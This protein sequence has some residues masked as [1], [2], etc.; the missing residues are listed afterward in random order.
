MDLTN[1]I[2][3]LDDEEEE[4]KPLIDAQP[5][6]PAV[7]PSLS[8]VFSN[9]DELD[10]AVDNFVPKSL[11][12]DARDRANK[13][14]ELLSSN[15]KQMSP[16]F[17][18]MSK[19][20]DELDNVSNDVPAEGRMPFWEGQ[21]I[22]DPDMFIDEIN[23]QFNSYNEN[24]DESAFLGFGES[25]DA[26][27]AKR[28]LPLKGKWDGIVAKYRSAATD[29]DEL[30]KYANEAYSVRD[31][32]TKRY[33]SM[34][35]PQRRALQDIWEA[36]NGDADETTRGK[37]RSRMTAE[38]GY[39]PYLIGGATDMM[40]HAARTARARKAIHQESNYQAELKREYDEQRQLEK[41]GIR[42]TKNGYFAGFPLNVS[43]KEAEILEN[44][45]A[46]PEGA[47]AKFGEGEVDKARFSEVFNASMLDFRAARHQLM[48][49]NASKDPKKIEEA[50][51]G[52]ALYK[53][54]MR[55]AL[56]KGNDMEMLGDLVGRMQSREEMGLAMGLMKEIA[57]EKR[58]AGED[59]WSNSIKSGLA[60]TWQS[61]DVIQ[62]AVGLQSDEEHIKK[63]AEYAAQ[64][65]MRA[66]PLSFDD[67]DG[68]GS[69]FDLASEFIGTM[70]AQY[71]SASPIG[72]AAGATAQVAGTFAENALE[73][74]KKSKGLNRFKYLRG[75]LHLTD[76]VASTKWG[77]K[78]LGGA[79]KNRAAIVGGGATAATVEYGGSYLEAIQ[80][81]KTDADPE[82]IDA[83][84]QEA[85]MRLLNDPKALAQVRRA[86]LKR[87][88][89]IAAVEA[90]TMF[91]GGLTTKTLRRMGATGA[92]VPALSRGVVDFGTGA[93]GEIAGM[94]MMHSE[95][96]MSTPFVT[97]GKNKEGKYEIGGYIG[98]N[99]EDIIMEGIAGPMMD[100]GQSA[101]QKTV[102]T[103][104]EFTQQK[105]YEWREA[106]KK[107]LADKN[108]HA[109]VEAITDEAI[110]AE[111]GTASSY[112]GAARVIGEVT[113][114]EHGTSGIVDL[115]NGKQ[116]EFHTA[117]DNESLQQLF[118]DRFGEGAM[119]KEQA[120]F[121]EK[122]F[123]AMEQ[124]G[125]SDWRD[126]KIVFA[127]EMAAGV[128]GSPMSFNQTNNV[129]TVNTSGDAGLSNYG[130]IKHEKTSNTSVTT[131]KRLNETRSLVA[132]LVHEV[133]HFSERYMVGDSK[134]RK[135]FEAIDGNVK[136]KEGKKQG[137]FLAHL[138]YNLDARREAE[139]ST[140][141]WKKARDEFY[142]RYGADDK[143]AN[144]TKSEW[145][146]FQFSRVAR[147]QIQGMDKSV[148]G[149][150]K[151]FYQKLR[152]AFK[153]MIGDKNLSNAEA[154]KEIASMFGFEGKTDGATINNSPTSEVADEEQLARD[155]ADIARPVV[156]PVE[157]TAD[158]TSS[159]E[160]DAFEKDQDLPLPE[161]KPAKPKAPKKGKK[162]KKTQQTDT[163]ESQTTDVSSAQTPTAG[164]K[165]SRGDSDVLAVRAKKKSA[166]SLK[167]VIS[168]KNS[169]Q[170]EKDAALNEVKDR[171][172]KNPKSS[173][174]LIL[175]SLEKQKVR[176]EVAESKKA[177]TAAQKNY[178]T[179][180]S[181]N[182]EKVLGKNIKG[183]SLDK[184]PYFNVN[185][186][187][188]IIGI[189]NPETSEWSGIKP[190]SRRGRKKKVEKKTD[191]PKPAKI[192]PAKLKMQNEFASKAFKDPEKYL[193][194]PAVSWLKNNDN[195]NVKADG[196][197]TGIRD[198]ATG[199]W[200]G[201]RNNFVDESFNLDGLQT[202]LDLGARKNTTRVKT[203][204]AIDEY[205]DAD[206]EAD[207]ALRNIAKARNMGVTRD[208]EVE[209]VAR[210]EKGDIIGGTFTSTD[211][212]NVSF[213]VVVSADAEGAGVGSTLVDGAIENARARFDEL[214]EGSDRVTMQIDVT[215]PQMKEMLERR[216]F[217]VTQ[218]TGKNR[219]SMEPSDYNNIGNRSGD[220][221]ARGNRKEEILKEGR[222]AKL[223][224]AAKEGLPQKD[225]KAWNALID[226]EKP[227]KRVTPP[228]VKELP[229]PQE[230]LVT[231]EDEAS[232]KGLR[233]L[234]KNLHEFV[235]KNRKTANRGG[236]PQGQVV[237]VRID[238]PAFK[239][240]KE[241]MEK[242]LRDAPVYASVIHQ[243]AGGKV[244]SKL[245]IDSIVHLKNGGVHVRSPETTSKIAKGEKDK[246]PMATLKG[247]YQ[248]R[249]D[250]PKDIDSYEQVGF[251]PERHSHFYKRG[252]ST[253]GGHSP[254]TSFKE[255]VLIGNTAYVK[256]A[257]F[258]DAVNNTELYAR[259]SLANPNTLG[260]RGGSNKQLN[261]TSN[262]TIQR[263]IASGRVYAQKV[264]GNAFRADS[265]TQGEAF[266]AGIS[267]TYKDHPVG[268]AV[269]V[270]DLDFY[271]DPKNGIFMSGDGLAGVAITDYADLVS[272]F[273]HPTSTAKP[274]EI[275]AEASQYAKTLDAYDVGGFLPNLYSEFGFK[276]VARVKFN[277]E[278]APDGWPYEL[279]GEPDI[280]LMVKDPETSFAPIAMETKGFDK[281][282]E[283]VPYMEAD[284]AWD[285]A[286]EIGQQAQSLELGARKGEPDHGLLGN[287][288]NGEILYNKSGDLGM[289]NHTERIGAPSRGNPWRYRESSGAVY[290]WEGKPTEMDKDAV[291]ILLE[292]KGYDTKN[293]KF[294]Q[295]NA[296][297]PNFAKDYE[298]AHAFPLKV[299]SKKKFSDEFGA[300]KGAKLKLTG[301]IK[302]P[303]GKVLGSYK[304]A[305]FTGK[306][307]THGWFF[308]DGSFVNVFDT[309]HIHALNDIVKKN[310][311][312]EVS[313]KVIEGKLQSSMAMDYGM[314]PMK[315]LVRQ[316]TGNLSMED[317]F[318]AGLVRVRVEKDSFGRNIY[319]EGNGKNPPIDSATLAAELAAING[320]FN[321]WWENAANETYGPTL[322]Y[323]KYEGQFGME[324][325][326]RSKNWLSKVSNSQD[327]LRVGTA[328]TGKKTQNS[329]NINKNMVP[330]NVFEKHMEQMDSEHLPADIRNEKNPDAK[331][332]KLVTFF[333]KNLIALHDKFPAKLRNRA[334]HWYDGALD[335]AKAAGKA[336]GKTAEQAAGVIAVMSP[337]K[338][339][340]KNVAQGQQFM[341]MWRTEQKTVITE[342]YARDVIEHIV[343]NTQ[344]S[345]SRKKKAPKDKEETERQKTI[346]LNYNK[347]ITKEV[348]AERRILLEAAIGSSIDQLSAKKDSTKRYWTMRIILQAKFGSD[349][350]TLAPEGQ[351][352]G[353]QLTDKGVPAMNGWG[354]NSEMKKAIS[355]LENGSIENISNNVGN[356]HKVRNFYNNIIA[357]NTPM[358]DATIDTHAVAA[359]HLLPFSGKSLEVKQNFG[360][361]A[362]TGKGVKGMYYMYLDAYKQAAQAK[363]LM[364][365][366]MQSI[367]WE[368]VRLLY[369]KE[370]KSPKFLGQMQKVWQ[371][372]SN[373]GAARKQLTS[374]KI[375][376]PIWAGGNNSGELAARQT[377]LR[378][379]GGSQAN[380]RGSLRFGDRRS[381]T[382]SINGVELDP[383]ED[384]TGFN[385]RIFGGDLG[386]RQGQ[387]P[388]IANAKANAKQVASASQQAFL[389]QSLSFVER[390]KQV[391]EI[392][393]DPIRLKLQDKMLPVRRLIEVLEE[394]KGG[395]FDDKLQT[396]VQH[397]NYHGKTGAELTNQSEDHER[398]IAQSI[399]ENKVDVEVLDD[400]LHLRH[401]QERNA[402]N[403]EQSKVV[404]VSYRKNGRLVQKQFRSYGAE[405][406]A[407]DFS[408]G[409]KVSWENTFADGTVE[410]KTKEFKEQSKAEAFA[411]KKIKRTQKP[412]WP[413]QGNIKL[414][415]GRLQGR[416]IS[417][418][419]DVE[420]G[421][422]YSDDAARHALALNERAIY[423]MHVA[424]KLTEPQRDRIVR[425]IK[426]IKQNPAGVAAYEHT[427]R[428]VDKM[429]RLSLE[430]QYKSGLI[431]KK[432]FDR[433][434]K[435]YKHFIPLR[436]WE[437][438]SSYYD[439]SNVDVKTQLNQTVLPISRGMNTMKHKFR[440]SGGLVKDSMVSNHLA[441][442]FA[443]ARQGIVESQKNEVMRSFFDLVASA[444]KD[445]ALKGMS[446]NLF[447]YTKGVMITTIDKYGKPRKQL[448]PRWKDDPNIVGMKINGVTVALRL[449]GDRLDGTS[450]VARALKNLGAEKSGV[451][452]NTVKVVTR[453]MAALRTTL[454][455]AFTPV[456]FV[457]D[458][459][460]GLYSIKG[461]DSDFKDQV[462]RGE[463]T[464]QKVEQI[465]TRAL[466][467]MYN[468][469][470][471][472]KAFQGALLQT[473]GGRGM[474]VSQGVEKLKGSKFQHSAEVQ[475]WADI[476]QDFS[477]NGGRINF[478][479]FDSVQQ[480]AK[481]FGSSVREFD[482]NDPQRMKTFLTGAYEFMDKTSGAVENLV[483]VTAYDAFV[484]EGISKQKAA[485]L[486]LNLTTNFTRKGEWTTALNGMYL[487]FNAG[488]QGSAKVLSTAYKSPKAR[489]FLGGAVLLG[490]MNSFINRLMSDE[491]DELEMSSWDR[492][493]PYSKTHNLHFFLPSFGEKHAKIPTPYGI[494]VFT[495]AGT[496]LESTI[497][498][499]MKLGDAASTW[500]ATALESFS[501][502][503]GS[504][505]ASALTPTALQPIMDLSLNQDFKGAPIY[506]EDKFNEGTP[507]SALHWSNT[508]EMSKSIAQGLNR[509]TGGDLQRSGAIDVSPDT[510]DYMANYI[511]GGLGSFIGRSGD[512]ASK[513]TQSDEASPTLNDIPIL[514]R[515]VGDKTVYYDTERFYNLVNHTGVSKERIEHY[516]KNG[517][518]EEAQ[519]VIQYEAPRMKLNSI[520]K[521]TVQK[522]LATLRR[523]IESVENHK[524]LSGQQKV[525]QIEILKRKRTRLMN[526]F[527]KTAE[528]MGIDDY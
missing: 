16:L 474:L 505:M 327:S 131:G 223:V 110:E 337:Q 330:R 430:R 258:G 148:L 13:A 54:V 155:S 284:S 141:A 151:K 167:R 351:T 173:A 353:L 426:T 145:W 188:T 440:A 21:K 116:H 378:E 253:D 25:D 392:A 198:P 196:T 62:H 96:G 239:K 375:S 525:D 208:R 511:F 267:R 187:G 39:D 274:K 460:M 305:K 493:S 44:H 12:N 436:G 382:D 53:R 435:A 215:N 73:K 199:E 365:R 349:Y 129:L 454:S 356:A 65:K 298:D 157:E 292:S 463:I 87:T 125:G 251:D 181:K 489:K 333:R 22:E 268:K 48:I 350:N 527:I 420:A 366:Q 297:S 80:H 195:F 490:F 202:E 269:E 402:V 101:L 497:F 423:A 88:G 49:A 479:G 76:A 482:P 466:R 270:K 64:S 55:E 357:P 324:L 192:A 528:R 398:P 513:V 396:Y 410:T 47:L 510:I 526:K 345:D 293:L 381:S 24:K 504:S 290:F 522:Q 34:G 114:T 464:E 415:K 201:E 35:D 329:V 246:F 516:R 113:Q 495:S 153:D 191:A 3:L 186:E 82:G 185:K 23:N 67:V 407:K 135:L 227:I 354:S 256:G 237:D 472:R 79:W 243:E 404:T 359:A 60:S 331:Y 370:I 401:A 384:P 57:D 204:L 300:R 403:R 299:P 175:D 61:L 281:V 429:N 478:F 123:G 203:E 313:K 184:N 162:K 132:N 221:G 488:V 372:E 459:G 296:N 4:K 149:M 119:N 165:P 379:G 452:V 111:K 419:S 480:L 512:L 11:Y 213:D 471:L 421:S 498:G 348:R 232:G 272:V 377:Q 470:T 326:A 514:R 17:D 37:A 244:G 373:E 280:V 112:R 465:K 63:Q 66:T 386:A 174:K 383:R 263:Q 134:V 58:D 368:A 28:G 394:T 393:T 27:R 285:Y 506:K 124:D 481:K 180:A 347:K 519:S 315:Q 322:L 431:G 320:E 107:D 457:R 523:Q 249:Y 241:D 352:L 103:S 340:F 257:V 473:T 68:A 207:S 438:V 210:N 164:N 502:I 264:R 486:A 390:L 41:Q 161:V 51:A 255:M 74:L 496:L 176:K 225:R 477:D 170:A 205:G 302:S 328:Y 341:E 89:A 182:P 286:G 156:E 389:N 434:R 248:R 447:S 376:N 117:K 444:N 521:K 142:A 278:Y 266:H 214:S 503:G 14:D 104:V 78:V 310:P 446:K 453:T 391:A 247:E 5:A 433:I 385:N 425:M 109:Q 468:P 250:I 367:T 26:E 455:P 106:T 231:K 8:H 303:K 31:E 287:V 219:W 399:A 43:K 451:L 259:P 100:V 46:D 276:P 332:E 118:V 91:A 282:R 491:D 234:H 52:F 295:L 344:P 168:S 194:K 343:K 6:K 32:F 448:D 150:I 319:L 137:M 9:K 312:S 283:A 121:L 7:P 50:E 358:G 152:P 19:F 97:F 2:D 45:K 72:L 437:E 275:L 492:V 499:N 122:F 38:T 325:G 321:L 335:I 323:P 416:T 261:Y 418:K 485:N 487:F 84:N 441:Y 212:D 71:G 102:D 369:P 380:I 69:A 226:Q 304:K 240:S 301:E 364:P 458:W 235:H 449:D 85:H 133:G 228:T 462:A 143:F 362:A 183:N 40:G 500:G 160:P 405:K 193:N 20:R 406:K 95:M 90:F 518:P 245:G 179:Q 10:T 409:F 494:N 346:R 83:L 413:R 94:K 291:E 81:V 138:E 105:H 424:G 417:T 484:K 388:V 171:V 279:L 306:N 127:S 178:A 411:K 334:T 517:T 216:G 98:E 317:G 177:E 422:G 374:R 316:L 355:I 507:D 92:V 140:E 445:P 224:K 222:N 59:R 120:T 450:S 311:D 456:N 475:K 400:Y 360:N 469:N 443:L 318:R 432:D 387:T 190:L 265:A 483:R 230:Y 146:A 395:T 56:V 461:L 252:D 238:I 520:Y 509:F 209:S 166:G 99:M 273:K 288:E 271:K 294:K 524:I 515:F 308:P 412:N 206:F 314:P 262:E 75:L 159:K 169:T 77:K 147:D 260:A 172:K 108:F 277:K 501:P 363:G 128:E 136:D 428:L 336:N 217:S 70:G 309:Y 442:A 439:H 339:W 220:L 197:L 361:P 338:D 15:K 233:I 158:E 200:K 467:N 189:Q 154:D 218:K 139:Q 126:M 254:L 427:S 414:K 18:E 30:Q 36:Q 508:T 144:D 342:S 93:A 397:E 476:F 86:A 289:M 242:G 229:K 33:L 163:P 42:F 408:T 1:N 211:T 371:N 130:E 115:G 29:R 307:V 236:V